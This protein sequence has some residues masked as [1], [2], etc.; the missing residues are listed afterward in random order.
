MA[1]VLQYRQLLRQG[2]QFTAYNY[3]EYAKR[4]T[5]D[6]F[7]ENKGVQDE[8]KVQ[9][10]VQKGLKE[11]QMMKVGFPELVAT[12]MERRQ[13]LLTAGIE[14]NSHRSVLPD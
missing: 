7:H 1:D 14:A 5:I 9:E 11:L 4:R 8:R 2:K 12:A 13:P 6:A 10:L 3:R